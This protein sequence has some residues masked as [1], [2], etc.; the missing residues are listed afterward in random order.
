MPTRKE[1]MPGTAF[2]E[3]L[4]NPRLAAPSLELPHVSRGTAA[5]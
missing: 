4:G 3:P 5:M 2:A 1:A